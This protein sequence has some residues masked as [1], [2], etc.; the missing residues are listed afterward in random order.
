M[1]DT[2][3]L[4]DAY[5]KIEVAIDKYLDL[6]AEPAGQANPYDRI[7]RL[8][9]ALDRLGVAYHDSPDPDPSDNRE[10]PPRL[11]WARSLEQATAA[12][13]TLAPFGFAYPRDGYDQAVTLRDPHLDLS[14]IADDL[15]Q[16]KW[17]AQNA[18]PAD[19]I[20]EF[21]LGYRS[22]WGRH[23]H[24]VRAYLQDLS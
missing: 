4:A 22:H 21:R 5:R 13:P 20:W 9:E 3:A 11:D 23:L 10:E 17:F 1:S 8:N 12:F 15:I 18:G 14:E 6:L 16:V 7:E 2:A 24:F 19:A